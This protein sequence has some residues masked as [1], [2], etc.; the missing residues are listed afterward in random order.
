VATHAYGRKGSFNAVLKVRD[1]RWR[2]IA[3]E[4]KTVEVQ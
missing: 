3:T 4:S 1:R 2:T